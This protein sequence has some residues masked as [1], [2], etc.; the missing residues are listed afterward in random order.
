M[1]ASLITLRA[2]YRSWGTFSV[3]NHRS[4][5][6]LPTASGILGLGA[7]CIGLIRGS[8]NNVKAWYSGFWIVTC[9]ST[10]FT[11]ENDFSK[12][13]FPSVTTDYQT[14]QGNFSMNGETR[15]AESYSEYIENTIDV[16]AIIPKHSEASIWLS[17][18]QSAF[19]QPRSTPYLGRRSCVLS[20]PLTE[21]GDQ[22]IEITSIEDLAETLAKR[23]EKERLGSWICSEYLLRIPKLLSCN[24]KPIGKRWQRLYEK[25]ILDERSSAMRFFSSRE[26]I[27]YL[28]KRQR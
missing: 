1:K 12:I 6:M 16:A 23:L 9:S 28:G 8:P 18:L 15:I 24:D 10:K 13:L 21:I 5:E 14:A 7:A 22:V 17:Q 25:T 20:A 19:E 4:T 3:G 11:D 2:N 27:D 26:V